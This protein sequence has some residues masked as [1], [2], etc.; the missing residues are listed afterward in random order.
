MDVSGASVN[1]LTIAVDAL[2]VNLFER[3]T[4]PSGITASV[5]RALGG[6]IGELI[7]SGDATGRTGEVTVLYPRGAIAAQRVL[8]VGLG[9]ANA[10]GREAARNA[11]AVAARRARDLGAK[12]VA[13]VAHGAGVNALALGEAAQ[14]TVEGARLGLY[15]YQPTTGS[16]PSPWSTRTR[17]SSRRSATASAGATPSPRGRAWP[18]PSCSIPPTWQRPSTW[19]RSPAVSR[20]TTASP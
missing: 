8:V 19:P 3:T 15:R 12:S 11:S 2:V 5:D 7:A 20:T 13:S 10:F 4:P 14:A 17:A 9:A 6:A 16:R 18:A 1:P